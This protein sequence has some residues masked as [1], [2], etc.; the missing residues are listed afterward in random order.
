MFMTVK[1]QQIVK[2][3]TMFWSS[4]PK[5]ELVWVTNSDPVVHNKQ[6]KLE[7][8]SQVNWWINN[9]VFHAF[10]LLGPSDV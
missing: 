3:Q 2:H 5:Q 8:S 1:F 4:L 6:T 7:T 9:G 10:D